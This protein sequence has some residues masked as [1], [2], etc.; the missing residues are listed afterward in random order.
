M[1]TAFI[2]GIFEDLSGEDTVIPTIGGRMSTGKFNFKVS[3]K[4]ESKIYQKIIVENSQCQIDG[5]YEC[6]DSLL[7]IEAKN[8][9]SQDFIIR[10][11]YY[12]YRLWQEKIK[13]EVILSFSLANT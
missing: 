7:M 12:P 9:I 1:K 2:S 6:S 5:G 11:L 4:D 13:K 3:S 10:Q 8:S